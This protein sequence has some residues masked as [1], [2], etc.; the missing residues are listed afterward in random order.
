MRHRE[1]VRTP[2]PKQATTLAFEEPNRRLGDRL[3][4]NCSRGKR[5]IGSPKDEDIGTAVNSNAGHLS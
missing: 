1:L 5:P 4:A 3:D 2:A